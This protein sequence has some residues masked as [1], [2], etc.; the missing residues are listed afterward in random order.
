MSQPVSDDRKAKFHQ[1]RGLL[2]YNDVDIAQRM[3]MDKSNYSSYINGRKT[4]TNN[5]LRKFYT[6]FG[7]E[8]NKLSVPELR[9]RQEPASSQ[10]ELELLK[11]MDN[12][13]AAILE[14]LNKLVGP[15]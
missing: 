6:A 14:A 8:I 1:D 3:A 9:E 11:S 7:E 5:F 10:T 13:L 12:R 4:I 2:L 15:E